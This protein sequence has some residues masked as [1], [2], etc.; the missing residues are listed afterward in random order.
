MKSISDNV[1]FQIC[2][3]IERLELLM[4]SVMFILQGA[5][6]DLADRIAVMVKFSFPLSETLWKTFSWRHV[7]ILQEMM[8]E[9]LKMVR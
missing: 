7:F 8:M 1:H 2:S 4:K 5:A 9:L 3:S 6:E